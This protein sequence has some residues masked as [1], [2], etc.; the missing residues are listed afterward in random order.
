MK[1]NWVLTRWDESYRSVM[2]GEQVSV[3]Q[4]ISLDTMKPEPARISCASLGSMTPERATELMVELRDAISLATDMTCSSPET[5]VRP[6]L[7][8]KKG[9][10]TTTVLN[11]D[12]RVVG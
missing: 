4:G 7:S 10:R 11:W 9:E 5:W 3:T 12:M 6:T 1:N 2:I 8:G